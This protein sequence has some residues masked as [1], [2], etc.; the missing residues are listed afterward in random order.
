[1]LAFTSSN[2]SVSCTGLT[3]EQEEARSIDAA[4]KITDILF[5]M[6]FIVSMFYFVYVFE[7]RRS[8]QDNNEM[9]KMTW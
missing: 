9:L 8:A 1:L 5:N 3:L 4:A 7:I 2:S 6:F